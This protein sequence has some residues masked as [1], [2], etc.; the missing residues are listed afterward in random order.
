MKKLGVV[1]HYFGK[2]QVAVMDLTEN[3]KMGDMV[4]FDGFLTEFEQRIDSLQVDKQP[5]GEAKKGSEIAIKVVER[6]RP[7]DE[8]FE[9]VE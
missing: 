8:M 7:G 4:R 3:I 9:V 5:I 1:T 2:I 6:V